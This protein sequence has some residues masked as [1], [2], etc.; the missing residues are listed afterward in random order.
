MAVDGSRVLQH[1][2]DF[3]PAIAFQPPEETALASGMAGDAADLLDQEQ[4]GVTVAIEA[5][6]FSVTTQNRAPAKR[7]S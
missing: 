4:D 2:F 7:V 5:E 6:K 1:G 3:D